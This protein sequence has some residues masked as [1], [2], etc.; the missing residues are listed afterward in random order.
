MRTAMVAMAYTLAMAAR[1]RRNTVAVCGLA[2]LFTWAFFF[3][4]HDPALRAIIPFGDDPYDAVG[5]FAVIASVLLAFTSFARV[6]LPRLVDRTGAAIYVLRT[7]AAVASCVLV[8]VAAD[9]VAMARH[10]SMWMGAAGQKNLL[11]LLTALFAS[12]CA[13][14]SLVRNPQGPPTIGRLAQA[15]CVW[16]GSLLVLCVYPEN[17]I[18]G[19]AGHLFTV[20]LGDLLLFAPVAMLVRAWLPPAPDVSNRGGDIPRRQIRYLPLLFSAITG[21]AVGA[22]ALL[23]EMSEGGAPPP[24]GRLFFVAAVYLGLGMIG[25]LIGYAF[26]GRLLGFVV[27]R[28]AMA[29]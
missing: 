4:K 24:L 29:P 15:A 17:L 14:L 12:S 2:L 1:L 25:L 21:L 9:T 22:V 10:P 3:A 13:V 16:L 6:F 7:Q 26:L 11:I 18:Q 19:I 23:T 28:H 5:S 20:V 8:T 27:D